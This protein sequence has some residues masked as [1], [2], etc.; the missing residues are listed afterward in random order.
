MGNLKCTNCVFTL[1]GTDTCM[2]TFTLHTPHPSTTYSTQQQHCASFNTTTTLQKICLT[3]PF[4]NTC[5]GADAKKNYHENFSGPPP[6]LAMKIMGQ[7]HRKA[8]S[9]RM[10]L[11]LENLLYF[12]SG[13][14]YQV[15]TI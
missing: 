9:R 2:H 5:R 12:F 1:W 13:P 7:S 14:P 3:G 6:P 11:L 10:Q 8:C 15:A 4:T